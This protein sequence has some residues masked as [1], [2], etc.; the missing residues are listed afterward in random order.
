MSI[1]NFKNPWVDEWKRGG[2]LHPD[3]LGGEQVLGSVS[4][5]TNA[6]PKLK[7]NWNYDLLQE[8]YIKDGQIIVKSEYAAGAEGS[9]F[10][11]RWSTLFGEDTCAIRLSYTLN[12]SKYNIPEFKTING[13]LT[14]SSN[15]YEDYQYILGAKEMGAYLLKTLGGPS[16]KSNGPI[17]SEQEVKLF[18]SQ[19]KALKNY[20]GIIF[21]DSLNQNEYG[22]SGHVDLVFS[23]SDGTPQMYGR[24]ADLKSYLSNR[25][26]G[27]FESDAQLEIYIWLLKIV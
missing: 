24:E 5:K 2:K 18:I 27:W 15:I 8:N 9:S 10:K 14:W 17:T 1:E 19:L 11:E 13:R 7:I 22:A 25:N 12:K 20:G 26:G 4:N 16:L 6:F 21:L 3:W 23:K